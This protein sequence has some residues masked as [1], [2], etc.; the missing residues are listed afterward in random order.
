MR[1]KGV[2][3]F[4]VFKLLFYNTLRK[5]CVFSRSWEVDFCE[6][7][8]L[9]GRFAWPRRGLTEKSLKFLPLCHSVLAWV[10]EKN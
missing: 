3:G 6:N 2:W 7:G 8:V 5:Y 9:L 1:V 4:V 10:C